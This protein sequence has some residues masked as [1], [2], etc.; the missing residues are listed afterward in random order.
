MLQ[1][2]EGHYCGYRLYVLSIVISLSPILTRYCD[3]PLVE[4]LAPTIYSHM[5]ASDFSQA[6]Q[7][8]ILVVL[9]SSRTRLES[10]PNT[11]DGHL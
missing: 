1:P 4:A 10:L 2:H 3:V 8:Q 9:G 6:R 11:E 5:N 7:N